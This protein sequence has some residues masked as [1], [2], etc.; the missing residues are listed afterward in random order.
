VSG[1][2][3][4]SVTLLS[5]AERATREDS[6]L[7]RSSV[8]LLVTPKFENSVCGLTLSNADRSETHVSN[9]CSL[10]GWRSGH[11]GQGNVNRCSGCKGGSTTL[12]S[13][14][15]EE[16]LVGAIESGVFRELR[17]SFGLS[18]LEDPFELFCWTADEPSDSLQECP[19]QH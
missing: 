15:G 7:V 3:T 1:L 2:V 16:G 17:D 8:N 18:K 4:G 6:T 10:K 13:R 11:S 19:L 9:D 5:G 14:I 12:G